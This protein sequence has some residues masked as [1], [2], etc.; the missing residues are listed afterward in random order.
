MLE[1]V[2][3]SGWGLEMFS[4]LAHGTVPHKQDYNLNVNSLVVEKLPRSSENPFPSVEF[5][6]SYSCDSQLGGSFVVR[7]PPCSKTRP[8]GSV[9]PEGSRPQPGVIFQA[10]LPPV[11][12]F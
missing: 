3:C 7:A 9:S 10:N 6:Y 1:N 11:T 12:Q 5:T 2:C 8:V 4:I